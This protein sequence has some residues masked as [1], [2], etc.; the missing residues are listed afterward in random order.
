MEVR[1]FFQ[2]EAEFEIVLLAVINQV[3]AVFIYFFLVTVIQIQRSDLIGPV[4]GV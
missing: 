3:I 4:T 2:T 1:H